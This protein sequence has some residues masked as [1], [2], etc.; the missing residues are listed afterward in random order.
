MHT[1]RDFLIKLSSRTVDEIQRN[2]IKRGKRNA[3]SRLYHANDDKKAIATWRLDLDGILHVFNVR[4][5]TP[6]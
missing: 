6:V 5:V 3:I 2:I 4:S 1:P